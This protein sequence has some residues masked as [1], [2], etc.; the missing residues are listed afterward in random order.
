M[1]VMN[2]WRKF[3]K[4]RA[5]V[6]RNPLNQN[7]RAEVRKFLGVEWIATGPKRSRSAIL[8]EFGANFKM[9]DVDHC[10]SYQS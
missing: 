5:F 1:P 4:I 7:F 6:G 10:C 9:K 3:P 2:Q 8:P